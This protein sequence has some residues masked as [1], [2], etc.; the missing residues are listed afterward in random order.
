MKS[1]ACTIKSAYQSGFYF[2]GKLYICLWVVL[3]YFPAIPC[4]PLKA[5]CESILRSYIPI[6][7]KYFFNRW[8]EAMQRISP[9]SE[10]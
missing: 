5:R 3:V 7:L 8:P 10:G 1:L 6:N 9:W 4:P 2:S